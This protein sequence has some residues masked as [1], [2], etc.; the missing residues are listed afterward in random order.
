[1]KCALIYYRLELP[2][3]NSAGLQTRFLSCAS[4]TQCFYR[5]Y[6]HR[7]ILHFTI[8]NALLIGREIRIHDSTNAAYMWKDPDSLIIQNLENYIITLVLQLEAIQQKVNFKQNF[9]LPSRM[10]ISAA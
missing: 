9:L 8:E 10:R 7:P 3:R 2:H 5:C 6:Q 4:S 1:M